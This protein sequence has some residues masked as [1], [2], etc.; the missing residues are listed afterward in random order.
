V[1]HDVQRRLA[2]EAVVVSA[3]AEDGG[4]KK[5]S[6]PSPFVDLAPYEGM[7]D[8][9]VLLALGARPGQVSYYKKALQRE[10]NGAVLVHV[11]GEERCQ[12]GV[13]TQLGLRCRRVAL[14]GERWCHQHHPDPPVGAQ[15]PAL[16]A[17]ARLRR[18]QLWQ[19][20]DGRVLE[21][22]YA[23][24]DGVHELQDTVREFL[25]HTQQ[26][27]AVARDATARAWLD[28]DEAAV[29][30]R[31]NAPRLLGPLAAASCLVFGRALAVRGLFDHRTWI[32]G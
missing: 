20:P 15:S 3:S 8:R 27:E 4:R 32:A 14:S 23:L 19:R 16:Q 21:A 2:E 29:Y 30:A 26:L 24:T 13:V 25:D 31:R 22:L 6:G 11:N 18:D 12:A 28:A 10:R 9:Q 17:R 5:R 1:L 7:P